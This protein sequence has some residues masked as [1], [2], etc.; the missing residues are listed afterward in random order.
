MVQSLQIGMLHVRQKNR[1]TS[2]LCL[3]QLTGPFHFGQLFFGCVLKVN[4]AADTVA[5][6][7]VHV[8]VS[9]NTIL[10][11]EIS[12]VEASGYSSHL[13]ATASCAVWGNLATTSVVSAS[14]LLTA[15]SGM[16]LATPFVD[17]Y[18]SAWQ[19]VHMIFSVDSRFFSKHL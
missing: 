6:K 17:R 15:K 9:H 4:Y 18:V 5:F 12:T 14:T 16:R 10:A 8:L 11:E 1:T 19:I 2:D 3:L 7:A 13:L